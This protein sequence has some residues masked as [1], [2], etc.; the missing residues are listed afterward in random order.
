MTNK[1][2]IKHPFFSESEKVTKKLFLLSFLI[3]LLFSSI[4][5]SL[6]AVFETGL[7]DPEDYENNILKEESDETNFLPLFLGASDDQQLFSPPVQLPYPSKEIEL[8]YDEVTTYLKALMLPYWYPL[9]EKKYLPEGYEW[10][11]EKIDSEVNLRTI[12]LINEREKKIIIFFLESGSFK[13]ILANFAFLF[14]PIYRFSFIQSIIE[15]ATKYASFVPSEYEV[16]LTGHSFWG[17]IAQHVALNLGYSA[18]VFGSPAVDYNYHFHFMKEKGIIIPRSSN[19]V[20]FYLEGDS[21]VEESGT[22]FSSLVAFP[23]R[24]VPLYLGR[25]APMIYRDVIATNRPQPSRTSWSIDQP[26]RH[27]LRTPPL[28]LPSKTPY[29]RSCNFPFSQSRGYCSLF[30]KEQVLKFG[31]SIIRRIK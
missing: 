11:S 4:T 9:V 17:W 1:K 29:S 21:A 3:Y 18:R 7:N 25:R 15:R 10:G 16:I 12:Y 27:G 2:N 14:E 22:H 28:I 19:I 26:V 24:G 23:V 8:D 6:S 31:H 20:N 30:K 5:F 13:S